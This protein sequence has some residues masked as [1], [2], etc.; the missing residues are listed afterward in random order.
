MVRRRIVFR[1]WVQGVGFRYRARHAASLYGCTG[2]VRNEWDGS[3]TMEIQGTPDRIEQVI[4]A[5]RAGRFV[6]IKDIESRELP[7]EEEE[8][9]FRAE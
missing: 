4:R 7:P 3:V 5:I 2:W 8:R 1:G 6:R 9:G